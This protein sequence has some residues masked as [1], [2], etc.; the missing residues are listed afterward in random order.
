M[1]IHFVVQS[2]TT[3]HGEQ[4]KQWGNLFQ[5]ISR[6]IH[7]IRYTKLAVLVF[8]VL[9]LLIPS[10]WIQ[11]VID[12]RQSYSYEATEDITRKMV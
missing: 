10:A 11:G 2:K 1:I 3:H 7:P 6:W 9:L 4:R 12:D 8:L 5:Q